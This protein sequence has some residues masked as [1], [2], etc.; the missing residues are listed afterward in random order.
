MVMEKIMISEITK[1]NFWTP[2]NFCTV[3]RVSILPI[4]IRSYSVERYLLSFFL[5]SLIGL[6]D[7]L[8]GWIAR[9]TNTANKLGAILDVSADCAVVFIFQGHLMMVNDWPVYLLVL[10]LISILSF[11]LCALMR[12]MVSKNLFGQYIGAVIVVLFLIA[13][14]CNA[15]NAELW[16]KVVR[17]VGLPVAGYI[18]LTIF[19]NANGFYLIKTRKRRVT[20]HSQSQMK[21]FR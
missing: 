7:I 2:A 11:C 21:A 4:L 15:I 1:S 8:D 13:S 5:V 3:L 20:M 10:S 12:R 19:E 14:L 9:K 18:N 16:D 6:S 17:I